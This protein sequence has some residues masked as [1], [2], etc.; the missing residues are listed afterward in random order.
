MLLK[1][2]S[3]LLVTA[4]FMLAVSLTGCSASKSTGGDTKTDGASGNASSISGTVRV[5]YAG[6][7]LEDGIDPLSGKK[8][9]GFKTFFKEDFSK[10]YPKIK[11]EIT[12]V[13]WADFIT[14]LQTMLL[15]KSVDV[16]G[17][18]GAE[19]QLYD[20][21]LLMGIDDLLAKD[22]NFKPDELFLDATWSNSVFNKTLSGIRYGLPGALGQ[23]MTVYDKKLFDDWGVEYLSAHPTPGEILEKAKK[24]TGKNP[25]T[26]EQNYGLF[27]DGNNL[28]NSLFTVLQYYYNAPGYEGVLTDDFKNIKWNLN[29]PE[30]KKIFEWYVEASKYCNPGFV[31]T[32][33]N[34]NYGKEKNA[35]AINLDVNGSVMIADYKM[36][37]KKDMIERFIPVLN[38]G[39]KGESWIACDNIVIAKTAKNI[40]ASWEVAKYLAS[41]DFAKYMYED[42]GGAPPIKNAAF[43]DPNDVYMKMAFEIAKVGHYNIHDSVPE[44]HE[45]EILPLVSGFISKAAQGKAPDIQKMLD[46]LHAKAVKW[47]ATK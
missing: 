9:R 45:S 27:F 46:D 41:Y 39:P 15:S 33:G 35:N 42:F 38:L 12:T 30:M 20:Q 47:S 1:K 44:F 40:D 28:A 10:K 31:S 3:V 2:I 36:S 19:K 6:A 25:K 7:Q 34:E 18:G 4:V 26:G 14:K 13:P 29:S 37:K 21:G 5:A 22:K 11:V 43:I 24:M 32:Q 23:R 8:I 17:A 16:L